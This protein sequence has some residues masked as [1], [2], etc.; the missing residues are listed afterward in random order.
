MPSFKNFTNGG[1]DDGFTQEST[2]IRHRQ[3]RDNRVGFRIEKVWA[4][5]FERC[6]SQEDYEKYISKYGKYESN[7][8]ISQAIVFAS[9]VKGEASVN[10]RINHKC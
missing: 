3:T 5:D 9:Y 4:N 8:Y 6:E 1:I 10:W 7:E 2:S